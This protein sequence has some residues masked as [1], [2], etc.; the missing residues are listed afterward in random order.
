LCAIAVH[1]RRPA[2]EQRGDEE[3]DDAG[4]RRAR[5]LARAKD[6]EIPRGHGLQSI[7]PRE[8]LAILLADQLL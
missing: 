4:I 8:Q 7:E 5:I 2:G 1:D 6:V 3:G